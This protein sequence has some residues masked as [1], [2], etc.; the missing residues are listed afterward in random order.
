MGARQFPADMLFDIFSRLP[1]KSFMHFRCVSPAWHIIIDDPCLAYMHQLRCP[2]E[3]KVLLL[4]P[5]KHEPA[6][7][8]LKE[9]GV[10]F[11]YAP[12]T[13]NT[14]I[15]NQVTTGTFIHYHLNIQY[16]EAKK[17]S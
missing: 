13:D 4:D 5:P 10:F 3:S 11:K 14:A 17:K 1:I 15:P 9:D 12:P 2:D 7:V 6:D 8:M 16:S